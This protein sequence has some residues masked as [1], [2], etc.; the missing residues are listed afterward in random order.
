M[1]QT[2]QTFIFV[3]ITE[4][5]SVENVYV[6]VPALF[7][8]LGIIVWT[9]YRSSEIIFCE[10]YFVNSGNPRKFFSRK[11]LFDEFFFVEWRYTVHKE[12]ACSPIWSQSILIDNS[13]SL[14]CNNIS[15]IPPFVSALQFRSLSLHTHAACAATCWSYKYPR[16][17]F[18]LKLIINEIFCQI[19][20]ELR[21]YISI[22]N[23]WFS[24]A[25]R[26]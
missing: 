9:I 13:D 6:F 17:Y 21:Y 16:K 1:K 2:I 14:E 4:P 5:L 3:F 22:W 19:I 7:Q 12:T 10:K 24:L 11:F 26:Q 20:S 23:V 15:P 18:T 8:T 25:F